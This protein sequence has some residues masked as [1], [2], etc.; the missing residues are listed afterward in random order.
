MV[1]GIGYI[2]RFM[3]SFLPCQLRLQTKICRNSA[4]K[5][6]GYRIVPVGFITSGR[7]KH[8]AR[9]NNFDILH[10]DYFSVFL[11]GSCH[12]PR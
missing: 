3:P 8:L 5:Q 9:P 4:I 10:D 7:L 2:R 1:H 6:Y 11:D 12:Y